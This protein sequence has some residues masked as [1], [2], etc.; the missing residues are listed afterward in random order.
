[1]Y[2]GEIINQLLAERK[3]K[4][5]E[6]CAYLNTNNSGIESYIKGNPSAN[7][8]EKIADFFKISIDDLFIREVELVPSTVTEEPVSHEDK[9]MN[10]LLKEII[11]EKERTIQLLMKQLN[12]QDNTGTNTGQKK[13][14]SV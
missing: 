2:K 4:K 12:K 14:C 10:Y 7:K 13:E 6:L 1:M 5:K 11:Q 9:E 8:L 3:I